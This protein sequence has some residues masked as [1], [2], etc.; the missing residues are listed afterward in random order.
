MPGRETSIVR[1]GGPTSGGSWSA[2][3]AAPDARLWPGVVRYSGF[4]ARSDVETVRREVP[5]AIVPV[6]IAFDA[7]YRVSGAEGAAPTGF[8]SFLAGMTS[9]PVLV[10]AGTV[11]RCIQIDFTPPGMRRLLGVPM[12]L[13]ANQALELGE[14]LGPVAR[15]LAERLFEAGV[16]GGDSG[17]GDSG[18]WGARFRL[19]DELLLARLR[20]T[21]PV[22]AEVEWAWRQL[23]RSEGRA[24][25]TALTSEL[26]WSRKR[27]GAAFR[28]EI[29]LPPK[30]V[31]RVLRFDH[32]RR[33]LGAGERAVSVAAAA[34]YADQAHM[35]REFG[36][37]AGMTPAR[38]GAPSFMGEEL[39]LPQLVGADGGGGASRRG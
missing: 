21:E 37:L 15:E 11:E 2:W 29:G 23:V 35:V 24:R 22:A 31:A 17:G 28:S 38:L 16:G 27:L 36:E 32:A 10:E 26:G 7:P 5:G 1:S 8:D 9:R 13:V 34:G 4:V 6:I 39:V 18:G 14:V 20:A 12:E 19:V 30:T 25:V 33:R 3:I